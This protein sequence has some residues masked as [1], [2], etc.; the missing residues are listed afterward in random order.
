MWIAG[1]I[2]RGRPK[3]EKERDGARWREKDGTASNYFVAVG[4]QSP[5]LAV[6]SR[7]E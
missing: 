4:E 2:E 3:K 7:G 6:I 1:E 5:N